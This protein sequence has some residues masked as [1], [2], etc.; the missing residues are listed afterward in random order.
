MMAQVGIHPFKLNLV[1]T[2]LIGKENNNVLVEE[3]IN[4][5]ITTGNY[6]KNCIL[7]QT[8]MVIKI[9]LS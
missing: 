4:I 7:S 1:K 3:I 9:E 2:H 5:S 6:P 8:F